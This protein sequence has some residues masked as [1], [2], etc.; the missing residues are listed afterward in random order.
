MRYD[1]AKEMQYDDI[2]Q[3]AAASTGFEFFAK[4]VKGSPVKK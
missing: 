1:L 2:A 3:A 4:D